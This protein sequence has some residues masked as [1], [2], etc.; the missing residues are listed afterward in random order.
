MSTPVDKYFREKSKHAATR[1][2]QDLALWEQWKKAPS[3]QTM[4]PLLR[5]FESP[6]GQRLRMWKAPNVNPAAM[7]ANM[8]THAMNA[9]QSYDP[10]MGTS[11]RSHVTNNLR[12]SHRFNTQQQ[13]LAYIPEQKTMHIGAIDAAADHLR[14]QLGRDPSFDEIGARMGKPGSLVKE[15]QGLRRADISAS[16]FES[17][18]TPRASSRHEEVVGMLRPALKPDEAAVFDYMYGQGG[19]PTVTATNDLAKR[20]G[21]S[22][23]Q[24]SRLKKR[25]E[26]AYKKY[27]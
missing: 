23:S 4:Q 18:P 21:K 9:L 19:K 7:E 16:A 12:K 11:L 6:I 22:P 25:V 15:I 1:D 2:A 13:N 8:L 20:M 17:D 24:I 14:E 10:G 5:R 27:L 26:T 3:P